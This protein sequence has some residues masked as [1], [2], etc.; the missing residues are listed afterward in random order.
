M[1]TQ[2]TESPEKEIAAKAYADPV[3]FLQFFLPHLFPNE[4][5]W[6]HRGI[7]AI[8]TRRTDF[9]LKYGEIDKICANFVW[10]EDPDDPQADRHAIFTPELDD[11][12]NILAVSMRV[13][14]YSLI[15]LPRGYSKTTLAG[16]GI[17]LYWILYQD[18]KF[19]V[20]IS[21]SATHAEMQ[22]G[23][24]RSELEANPRIHAIFG[25]IVPD[26][27][28]SLKWT[29]DM[30]QT[31][32]GVTAVARGRG[33]QIRG[34]NVGGQRPDCILLDDVEDRDSVK[35][36]DQRTKAKTWM[37]G[38]VIPALPEM[39][40]NAT[41]LGLG[42]LLHSEALLMTLH[43][44]P[45]WTSVIFG[46]RDTQGDLLWAANMNE[47]KIEAKK[48]SFA[49]AGQLSQ[50][51]LEY[52]NTIR[53]VESQ[54]FKPEHF[55]IN[56]K[57]REDIIAMAIA[58]DPAISQ[59]AKADFAAIGVVGMTK[60]GILQGMEFWGK[61]GATP[62][63]MIDKY[64]ELAVKYEC[65]LHGIESI[66]FQ[67]VLIHLVREEMFRKAK[68]YGPAAYFEIIP[69]TH[70]NKRE[71]K[72]QR[73]VGI[74]QPRFAA[75]YIHFQK[76]FPLLETQLQDFPNGKKD[77]PDVLAMCVH[78]LDPA[79]PM[80]VGEDRDPGDDEYESLEDWRTYT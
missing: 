33:G 36:D 68:L 32:T 40:E 75:G 39:Q 24:V 60:N 26:R 59:K 11:A 31:L 8:L 52:E 30:L 54:K 78:L 18:K 76:R 56:P 4:V 48:A 10:S 73:I 63:E 67:Q 74:L 9:L 45:E 64:F 53:A 51:Y 80:A 49:R 1:T 35:T 47:R 70:S 57:A 65:T 34:L 14:K 21:E 66:A 55:I 43:K 17:V 6:V 12:G 71:S 19:P 44:D 29:G 61:Q 42:T 23:N 7:I 16:I 46:V 15:M 58:L 5:P 28:S 77:V 2:T 50:Y 22:L 3:F 62:R 38:D 13:T 25:N 69:I 37:Y 27:Q 79:A 20:Y 72:D 41:I